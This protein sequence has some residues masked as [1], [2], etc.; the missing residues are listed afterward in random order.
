MYVPQSVSSLILL[1]DELYHVWIIIVTGLLFVNVSR[2][3]YVSWLLR[4]NRSTFTPLMP[5]PTIN[6]VLKQ[7]LHRQTMKIA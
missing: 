1:L 2:S 6:P 5:F 3:G 7:R 4:I